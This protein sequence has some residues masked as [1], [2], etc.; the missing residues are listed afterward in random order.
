MEFFN[1]KEEVLEVIM[2]QK[3]KELFAKGNFSPTH[4]SF[5]DSDITYDNDN[6]E[7]QNSITERINETPTLK[8][9]T[10]L[11][12][13]DSIVIGEYSKG[14]EY[15]LKCELGSKTTGDQYAPAWN[16]KF[17]KSPTFQ[18]VGVDREHI[19]DK[20]KYEVGFVPNVDADKSGQ[21]LIPQINILTNRVS[22]QIGIIKQDPDLLLKVDEFNAFNPDEFSEYE[23]ECYLV[24]SDGKLYKKLSTE[25][26]KK[27]IDIYFDK[28]ANV[29][30]QI[31][32]KDIYGPQVEVDETT[33]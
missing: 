16:L 7:I 25:E 1:R 11:R 24:E 8:A 21:E 17:L 32:R 18:Y 28:M 31:N 23:V 29:Q 6:S 5:H 27:Y 19:A 15:L 20:K 12:Q 26:T 22:N 14:E 9:P 2:T 33:C 13:V 4:Y 3:G 10:T 30:S